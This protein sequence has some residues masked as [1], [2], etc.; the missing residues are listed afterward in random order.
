MLCITR[1][2]VDANNHWISFE[3]YCTTFF[4]MAASCGFRP[5]AIYFHNKDNR[6]QKPHG[7]QSWWENICHFIGFPLEFKVTNN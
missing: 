7:I 4:K 1:L 6:A 3:K 2:T 5:K